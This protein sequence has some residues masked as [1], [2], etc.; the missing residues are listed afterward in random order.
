MISL[1][2]SAKY[3]RK[4]T[5]SLPAGVFAFMLLSYLLAVTGHVSHITEFLAAYEIAGLAA[6]VFLRKKDNKHLTDTLKDPGLAIFAVMAV[7]IWIVSLHMKVTN[8]DDFHSW[9]IQP[10]DM[11]FAD[12]L[13]TGDMASSYYRDYFPL[14]QIMDYMLLKI[15]GRYSEGAMFA[16]LWWLMLV[17]LLPFLHGREKDKI[18]L[19]I[20]HIITGLILP[21]LFSFQFLHCL[22]PDILVTTLFGCA[23]VYIFE[24]KAGQT[25]MYEYIRILLS[26][27][28]LAVLKTTSMIFAMVCI[29]VFVIKALDIRKLTTVIEC[30]LLPVVTASFWLSWKSFCRARGN[31]TYLSDNLRSSLSADG[32]TF[33]YYTGSTIKAFVAKLF[34]Y[35]LNDGRAGLTSFCI[36]LFFVICFIVYRYIKGRDIRDTLSFITVILGMAG[37]LLVMIYI[38]LFVFEEW[39]ALSLS[40]YDRYISTYFGAMMYLGFYM[41]FTVDRL[42][43]AWVTPLLTMLMLFTVNYPYVARTLVPAGYETAYGEV[44]REKERIEAEYMERSGAPAHYGE[45]IVIIDDGEGQLRDKVLPYAAVPGVVKLIR[46]DAEGKMPTEEEI[47]EMIAERS[48]ERVVDMR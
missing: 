2:L 35:G 44:I 22:G 28:L 13:P 47:R 46:P 37:Y 32:I 36:L 33:P 12:G 9:A 25:D 6:A 31:T 11:F 7:V 18:H 5:E 19:F 42:L 48:P 1:A 23:L 40:S 15:I 17:T 29:S 3:D 38:Y 4:L 10:K 14:V 45:K 27:A 30:L 43:P 41:L 21:F 26:V 34:T 8:F 20:C 39:E 16:M 24:I